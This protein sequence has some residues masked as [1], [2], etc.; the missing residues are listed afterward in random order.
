MKKPKRLFKNRPQPQPPRTIIPLMDMQDHVEGSRPI[1]PDSSM[2]RTVT[3]LRA[4]LNALDWPSPEEAD[5]E[6]LK[7]ACANAAINALMNESRHGFSIPN[8]AEIIRHDRSLLPIVSPIPDNVILWPDIAEWFT[9][10]VKQAHRVQDA[11][12]CR[13]LCTSGGGT[14]INILLVSLSDLV[15]WTITGKIEGTSFI[16][17]GIGSMLPGYSIEEFQAQARDGMPPIFIAAGDP[18]SE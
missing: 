5:I 8:V 12:H 13:L 7:I 11:D 2:E 4:E 16:R 17:T 10:F 6:A 1:A 9:A 15:S 18:P 14:I 3:K